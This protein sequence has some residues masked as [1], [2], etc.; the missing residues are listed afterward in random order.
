MG[1]ANA[2]DLGIDATLS[3]EGSSGGGDRLI[4]L[5]PVSDSTVL[6]KVG[7]GFRHV[8]KPLAGDRPKAPTTLT[9]GVNGMLTLGFVVFLGSST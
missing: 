4:V 5:R 7:G 1:D 6:V 9:L 3:A 8:D 2:S